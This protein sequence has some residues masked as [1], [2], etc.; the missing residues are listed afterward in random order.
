[1]HKL[2]DREIKAGRMLDSGG[3]TPL[4]TGA[5][6]LDRMANADSRLRRIETCCGASGYA[7][8]N[9]EHDPAYPGITRPSVE[10]STPTAARQPGIV[11]ALPCR[12]R[13]P[14]GWTVGKRR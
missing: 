1:M 6:T 5:H 8:A 3:L 9:K 14:S 2:A 11:L 7:L 4:A 12:R 13:K 10:T